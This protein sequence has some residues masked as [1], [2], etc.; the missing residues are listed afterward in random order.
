MRKLTQLLIAAFV[1]VGTLFTLSATASANYR[2]QC[3]VTAGNTVTSVTEWLSV[4]RKEGVTSQAE[5]RVFK[6]A[7]LAKVDQTTR[8]WMTQRVILAKSNRSFRAVDYGCRGGKLF[9]VGTRPYG[10]G[11][12]VFVVLPK[13]Y[14][15]GDVRTSP[16]KGYVRKVITVKVIGLS[17]CGNPVRGT[18]T[19]VV[20]VKKTKTTPK[21]PATKPAA[22]CDNSQSSTSNSGA[23]CQSNTSSQT[24]TAETTQSG[25]QDCEARGGTWTN[26]S[27]CQI[28][29]ISTTVI[30]QTT[31]QVNANCSKVIIA[32]GDGSSVTQ[33]RDGGGNTV[34]ESY[35]SSTTVTPPPTCPSG[36]TGTYP[37]CQ[38]PPKNPVIAILSATNLNDI[39]TGKTSGPYYVEV[40]AS[41]VGGSLTIDPSIGSV[42]DCNGGAK[43]GSKTLS[44]PKGTTKFCFIIYAPQDPAQP[45]TMTVTATAVLGSSID[46]NIDPLDITYPVRP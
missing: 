15:K 18:T 19:V 10:K 24:A 7:G 46:K 33:W 28:T 29:N 16:K 22:T 25:K 5:K 39:P 42:S 36:T 41:D 14:A 23:A 6:H 21:P 20:Y 37:N 9:S 43:E 27:V 4:L 26:S 31:I 11:K 3:N 38:T 13:A 17:D 45:K 35:C 8:Q 40:S 2:G 12:A 44:V 34:T 30:N 1:V 32:Y